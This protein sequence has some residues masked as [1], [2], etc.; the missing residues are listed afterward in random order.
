MNAFRPGFG[1]RLFLG[2]LVGLARNG[3]TV[4][5]RLRD[6]GMQLGAMLGEFSVIGA[7]EFV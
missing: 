2:L 4:I 6:C 3:R 5:Q 7:R 1:T